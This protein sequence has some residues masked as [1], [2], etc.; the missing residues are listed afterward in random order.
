LIVCLSVWQ[1]LETSKSSFLD[2][3]QLLTQ[4]LLKQ[5]HAAPRL[6]SSLQNFYGHHHDQHD[7]V[8]RYA[9]SIHQMTMDLLLF[10]WMIFSF[11][12]HR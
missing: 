3:A 8:D 10:M 6:K 9:I 1:Q 4:R 12:Y 2:R 11:L 5:G 7:L